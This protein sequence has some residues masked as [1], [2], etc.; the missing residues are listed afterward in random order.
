MGEKIQRR[1]RK[2]KGVWEIYQTWWAA[3]NAN[4]WDIKIQ[5]KTC[6]KGDLG[7]L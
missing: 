2:E 3:K 7:Q 4:D 6:S 1:D 5:V